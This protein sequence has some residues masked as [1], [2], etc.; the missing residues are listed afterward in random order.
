VA[1][2]ARRK[3]GLV[4]TAAFPRLATGPRRP[5]RE[6]VEAPAIRDLLRWAQEWPRSD[7]LRREYARV[8]GAWRVRVA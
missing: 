2:Q 6:K 7:D 5:A 1:V 4:T 3:A 8:I